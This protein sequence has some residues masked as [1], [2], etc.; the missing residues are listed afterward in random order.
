MPTYDYQCGKCK[1]TFEQ[2]S[3]IA[4]RKDPEKKPCPKCGKKKVKQAILQV[5]NVG[6]PLAFGKQKFPV[7]WKER[8]QSI[9]KRTAGSK[10]DKTSTLCP[11]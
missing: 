5:T 3:R 1:H 7:G 11:I 4:D 2:S 8:L 6:D 9:H 10:L